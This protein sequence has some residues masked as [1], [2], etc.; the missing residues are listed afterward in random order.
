VVGSVLGVLCLVG[1]PRAGAIDTNAAPAHGQP[2]ALNQAIAYA[3][4]HNP[5]LAAAQLRATATGERQDRAG[6][7]PNPFLRVSAED[8]ASDFRI[9]DAGETKLGIE[10]RVPGLGKRPLRRL[11][12]SVDFEAA[13]FAVE[14]TK[15]DL[16]LSVTEAV[17]GLNAIRRMASLLRNEGQLLKQL[18][19]VA[20]TQYAAGT[21]TQQDVI[22]AQSEATMLQQRRIDIQTR[23]QA[24]K[25]R[26]NTLLGRPA[27]TALGEVAVPPLPPWVQP[28]SSNWLARAESENPSLS[29]ARVMA[30]KG[31]IEERL[32]TR[33]FVPDLTL[34]A[35]ATRVEDD[36]TQMLL[37][38]GI[39]L[40]IQIPATRAGIREAN[41]MAQAADAEWDAL[42]R[43][44]AGQ[45][46]EVASACEAAWQTLELLN[47][48]LIPQ[49]EA[50]YRASE[51]AYTAGKAD[52]M[53]LLESQRFRLDVRMKV[54]S[55]EAEAATQRARLER[56]LGGPLPAGGST[57]TL[58][59]YP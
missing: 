14:E 29:R 59:G 30:D 49:A 13:R 11:A 39:D 20:K 46:Q 43:Q 26:L 36:E 25:A 44:T 22:K 48:Q 38:L 3:L 42:R 5:S 4:A 56:L 37:G 8:P 27:D 15:Q 50:R 9:D 18:E 34:M 45:I 55:M 10:Q 47:T 16:I 41:G 24:L 6:A 33:E 28:D 32:A 54:V 23:E 51:A 21:A 57:A 58:G 53:D 2:L 12:A 1:L 40:P 31:R 52:F 35:E 19:T 17:Q 7:F